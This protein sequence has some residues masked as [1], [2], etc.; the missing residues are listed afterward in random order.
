MLILQLLDTILQEL[1]LARCTP[2]PTLM[3]LEKDISENFG[4]GFFAG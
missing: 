1:T 2:V 4:D 3:C